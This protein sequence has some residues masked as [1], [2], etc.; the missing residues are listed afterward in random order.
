MHYEYNNPR[1]Y[2]VQRTD[3]TDTWDSE[4]YYDLQLPQVSE[5]GFYR[6]AVS[7]DAF[8]YSYK[9]RNHNK[10]ANVMYYSTRYDEYLWNIERDKKIDSTNFRFIE[11]RDVTEKLFD[12]REKIIGI[13]NFYKH[14][15]YDYKTKKY[16]L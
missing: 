4:K 2:I 11:T 12:A 5:K 1:R 14:I 10:A 3:I 7:Y 16:E 6:Q 13:W 15:G 9:N 8:F